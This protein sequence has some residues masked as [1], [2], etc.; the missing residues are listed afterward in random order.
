MLKNK[1][2]QILR[3]EIQQINLRHENIVMMR[4]IEFNMFEIK[5]KTRA[6]RTAQTPGFLRFVCQIIHSPKRADNSVNIIFRFT[7]LVI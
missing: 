2:F 4:H 1:I 5:Y 3:I 7:E 6:P